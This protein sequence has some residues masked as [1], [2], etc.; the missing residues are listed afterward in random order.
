MAGP[1]GYRNASP[2][3]EYDT[4]RLQFLDLSARPAPT[5]LQANS[6]IAFQ[7]NR[8]YQGNF[9][10]FRILDISNPGNLGLIIA[11]E[12]CQG[13]GGQG[14]VVVYGNILTRSWDVRARATGRATARRC[15]SAGRGLHVFDI[16]TRRIRTWWRRCGPAAAR[17]PRPACRIRPTT[18]CGLQHAVLLGDQLH[19]RPAA[20]GIQVV[21]IPLNA[22][23]NARRGSSRPRRRTTS[24]A[25]TPASSSAT[26]CA[27]RARAATASRSG[28]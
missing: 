4:H 23:Q 24:A 18:G 16:R 13:N 5:L 15:P 12:A 11:Y 7:G 25:T 19:R 6:D 10:G 21:E 14:D 17:T 27:R 3:T 26:S 9:Q 2:P 20:A 22:P 28:R 8:A 1:S